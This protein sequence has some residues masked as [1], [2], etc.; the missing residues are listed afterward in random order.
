ML[1]LRDIKVGFELSCIWILTSYPPGADSRIRHLSM[2]L[3][4]L[5]LG[6]AQVEQTH[7]MIYK[8]STKIREMKAPKA[9]YPRIDIN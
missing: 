1:N 6:G 9:T 7:E 4:P 5:H 8:H 3:T 2:W